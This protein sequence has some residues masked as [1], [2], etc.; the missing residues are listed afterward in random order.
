MSHGA[1]K[2][3][4]KGP[5]TYKQYLISSEV[6]MIGCAHRLIEPIVIGMV[7]RKLN[8]FKSKR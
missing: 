5:K 4:N 6:L 3:F 8:P 2:A 1:I 7:K